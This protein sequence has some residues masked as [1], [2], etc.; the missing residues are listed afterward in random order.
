MQNIVG[1]WE[2][3]GVSVNC[4]FVVGSVERKEGK[5]GYK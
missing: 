4:E 3:P 1:G 5:K 2:T